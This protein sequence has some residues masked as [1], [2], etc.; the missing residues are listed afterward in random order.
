MLSGPRPCG[1]RPRLQPGRSGQLRAF[2]RS[3]ACDRC[4]GCERGRVPRCTRRSGGGPARRLQ[5]NA[6]FAGRNLSAVADWSVACWLSKF[7]LQHGWVRLERF[8]PRTL[9]IDLLWIEGEQVRQEALTV[10]ARQASGGVLLP[11]NRCWKWLRT[12]GIRRPDFPCPMARRPGDGGDAMH[13]PILYFPGPAHRGASLD[14]HGW[15]C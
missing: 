2:Q 1:F 4:P 6:A 7:E 11:S 8:G 3:R 9:D 14:T 15:K 13:R 10:A 12:R 5:I